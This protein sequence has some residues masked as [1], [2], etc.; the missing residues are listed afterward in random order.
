MMSCRHHDSVVDIVTRLRAGQLGEVSGILFLGFWFFIFWVLVFIFGV[1][2]FYFWGSGC[3]FW[4][5]WFFI[6]GVLVFY[7]WVLVFYFWQEQFFCLPKQFRPFLD[8]TQ[9][10]VQLVRPLLPGEYIGRV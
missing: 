5:F 7:F 1:L 6:F 4:G 3:L 9:P 10:R 8:P 2:V